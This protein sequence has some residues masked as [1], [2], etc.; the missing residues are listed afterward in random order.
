MK[1]EELK[2]KMESAASKAKSDASKVAKKAADNLESAAKKVQLESETSA[3][4]APSLDPKPVTSAAEETEEAGEKASGFGSTM[5]FYPKIEEAVRRAKQSLEELLE[6]LQKYAQEATL[7][8]TVEEAKRAVSKLI[9]KA[10]VLKDEAAEVPVRA[11]SEAIVRAN[12]AIEKLKYAAKKFDEKNKVSEKVSDLVK[13]ALDNVSAAI[14]EVSQHTADAASAAN[15]RLQGVNHGIR[16]RIESAATGALHFALDTL[17]ELDMKFGLQDKAKQSMEK[18]DEKLRLQET[19]ESLDKKF[20]ITGKAEKATEKL[21]SLSKGR[22]KAS[23][24]QG[25]KMATEGLEMLQ[26]E[27]DKA[28]MLKQMEA[29]VS[30]E[31]QAKAET[32]E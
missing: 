31:K 13:P 8:D 25:L 1:S 10:S 14:A 2:S 6:K 9:E 27:Y 23:Y 21:D 32:D 18:L 30:Q 11:L 15:A 29:Q 4:V 19:A 26:E 3:E 20:G 17:A 22:L 12:N 28:L 24:E 16:A 7:K 5:D